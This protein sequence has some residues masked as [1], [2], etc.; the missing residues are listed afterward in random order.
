[1]STRCHIAVYGGHA[2]EGFLS[3]IKLRR[4]AMLYRHSDGYPGT[5]EDSMFRCAWD[6]SAGEFLPPSFNDETGPEWGV[7]WD[8]V[9]YIR[10]FRRIR[11]FHDDEYLAA[12]LLQY[13]CNKYDTYFT[14]ATKNGPTG[15][16]GHGICGDG[17]VHGDTTQ[18]S[19][20]TLSAT[21]PLTLTSRRRGRLK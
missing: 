12:R 16:L 21:A 8:I 20:T 2:V 14:G 13:L 4:T 7:L 1:M 6:Q 17:R 5:S 19:I 18:S 3:N 10:W 11:G 15:V 9:P